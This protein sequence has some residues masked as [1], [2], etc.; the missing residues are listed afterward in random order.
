MR[1]WTPWLLLMLVGCATAWEKHTQ[2]RDQALARLAIDDAVDEQRWLIDNAI[3]EAPIPERGS[4]AEF[5]RL[6]QLADLYVLAGNTDEAIGVL[7]TALHTVPTRHE[8]VRRRLVQLPL[9]PAERRRVNE[10]FRWN[11]QALLPNAVAAADADTGPPECWSYRVRQIHLRRRE[12]RQSP[13][14]G[15][16]YVS[17]DARSWRYEERQDAWH[18]EGG[19]ME[20]IGAE[21]ERV[22]GPPRPRYRAITAAHDGFFT[23]GPVPPCHRPDWTGPF[24]AERDRL[25]V[26]QQ[27]PS[28]G[29]DEDVEP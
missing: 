12:V 22:A 27:L 18:A 16:R 21:V 11:L 24:D 6:V 8:E 9:T 1:R 20:D 23:E 28:S 15:E 14:G 2:R 13:E 3:T 4:D 26:A 29:S 19:W 7:R 25:F 5:T 17:Y 10:E